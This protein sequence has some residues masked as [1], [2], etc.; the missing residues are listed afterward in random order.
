MVNRRKLAATTLY[1]LLKS[2]RRVSKFRISSMK[3]FWTKSIKVDVH[4]GI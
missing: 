1:E 3:A 4:S 2:R